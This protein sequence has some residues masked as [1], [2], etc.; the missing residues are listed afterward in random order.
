[1]VGGHGCK[2]C[3]TCA[4]RITCVDQRLTSHRKPGN[5][6]ASTHDIQT[7][8]LPRRAT[9]F[10]ESSQP[11]L[12]CGV[13]AGCGTLGG[14]DAAKE[15]PRTDS[16]RVPQAVRHRAL[17]KPSFWMSLNTATPPKARYFLETAW[18]VYDWLD[19][20]SRSTVE[21]RFCSS[22]TSSLV[23]RDAPL[24]QAASQIHLPNQSHHA[25]MPAPIQRFQLADQRARRLRAIAIKHA[26]VVC[27]EQR[28]FDAGKAG[29]LAAL[30][31]HGIA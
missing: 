16:R 30:D 24:D 6:Q 20:A 21:R 12:W 14:M 5:G 2:R 3:M 4:G 10:Q 18:L 1:M 17:D 28:V 13:L 11:T 9:R 22:A 15:P 29:A 27:I 26:G 23:V 25:S 8:H 19:N 31:H 7:S